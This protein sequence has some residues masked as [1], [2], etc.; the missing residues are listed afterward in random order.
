MLE[1][2]FNALKSQ[3]PIEPISDKSKIDS[4]YKYWRK[5][6]MYSM[7]IGYATFYFVRK[8][9]SMAN[10]EI[11]KEFGFSNTEMGMIL[12]GA[13]IIYAFSKFISGV[14]ADRAN[15]RYFMAIGLTLCAMANILFGLSSS[16]TLFILFWALNNLFQGMGMPP[17]SRLL[18]MWYSP[19]ESGRA[20]G[21]WNSCHQF[22]SFGIILIS[23]FI[24]S[25]L[26]WRYAFFIPAGFAIIVAL[27]LTNRLRDSPQS[28]G[29]PSIESHN[30]ENFIP[31]ETL[32]ENE[33]AKE[34]FVK[35]ILKNKVI[36]IL[37]IGNFF[38]YIVRMGI[39]DWGP[40]FLVES[41][42]L[43]IQEAGLAM[44]TFEIAGMTGA[45]LAGLASD[46]I[47]KGRRGPV[48]VIFMLILIVSIYFLTVI[49]EKSFWTISINLIFIGFFVYGPQMLVAVA[50][51]DYATS[52]AA[53]TAVGMTGFFGYMGATVCGL[54]TGMIVDS[55]GWSGGFYFWTGSAVI[56]TLLF[57]TTWNKIA[58]SLEN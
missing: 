36:W 7:M 31:L 38:V 58:P 42:G 4:T 52:K 54:G 5:R 43:S 9:F 35:Y 15:A 22:G 47:F 50:A 6:T 14:L 37:S 25:I 55:Y 28:L 32:Q 57:M 13:T 48:K 56:G 51:A 27:F 49:P 17:C 29:L 40:K 34:I 2:I 12:G 11:A 23:G 3:S 53:A 19:K 20:W 30:N 46:K 44:S 18:T 16:L 39:L 41:K 21:I 45:F 1:K 33:S 26:G 24:I 8:N 10:P